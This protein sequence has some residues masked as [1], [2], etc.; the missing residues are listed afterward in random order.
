MKQ[1]ACMF[2]KYQL[3][4]RHWEL[5]GN[6]QVVTD[7]W[8]LRGYWSSLEEAMDKSELHKFS[9]QRCGC[10]TRIETVTAT[11]EERIGNVK[12]FKRR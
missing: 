6:K 11:T 2:K 10:E 12:H 3:Y 9:N 7:G 4:T 1:G 5:D 8:I